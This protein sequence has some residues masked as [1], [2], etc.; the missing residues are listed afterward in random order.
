VTLLLLLTSSGAVYEVSVTVSGLSGASAAPEKRAS[1]VPSSTVAASSNT[2]ASILVPLSAVAASHVVTSLN[3]LPYDTTVS[4]SAVLPS[5]SS[6]ASSAYESTRHTASGVSCE[7]S[8]AG[9]AYN[10]TNDSSVVFPGASAASGVATD[11]VAFVTSAAVVSISALHALFPNRGF[12]SQPS[13]GD[14][15]DTAGAF[16]GAGGRTAVG[17]VTL[18]TG[19]DNAGT[20]SDGGG[21][22]TP[23]SAGSGTGRNTTGTVT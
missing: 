19:R 7:T 22:T 12:G 11:F 4:A 3:F 16:V 8:V 18:A 10:S 15:R 5:Q 21:R 23:G 6:V 2:A 9:G 13:L 14:G 17:S 20:S 1:Y